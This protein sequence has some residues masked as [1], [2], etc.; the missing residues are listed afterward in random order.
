MVLPD[1]FI[2]KQR[3]TADRFLKNKCHFN[4]ILNDFGFIQ[5]KHLTK[6]TQ[7]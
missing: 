2:T 7:F 6:V 1:I 3:T 4:L 5:K